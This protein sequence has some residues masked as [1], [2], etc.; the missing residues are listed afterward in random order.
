MGKRNFADVI[1]TFAD[2]YFN[3]LGFEVKCF[4]RIYFVADTF[5]D[6]IHFVTGYI[7]WRIYFVAGYIWWWIHYV[8]IYF[9]RIHFVSDTFCKCSK[10]TRIKDSRS[11]QRNSVVQNFADI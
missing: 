2:L 10:L 8:W 1:T 9:V 5:C 3:V 7:L 6:W 4:V 11:V